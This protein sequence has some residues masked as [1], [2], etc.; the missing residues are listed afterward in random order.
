MGETYAVFGL[1]YCH[2]D[3]GILYSGP[4]GFGLES[5]LLLFS[6]GL[7]G[8]AAGSVSG[9]GPS[10]ALAVHTLPCRPWSLA[11]DARVPIAA[12]GPAWALTV[13]PLECWPWSPGSRTADAA[14]VAGP[15]PD[16]WPPRPSS[17]AP[18]AGGHCRG[19]DSDDEDVSVGTKVR[20]RFPLSPGDVAAPL[21]AA[22]RPLAWQLLPAAA[23]R[24]ACGLLPA[25][26][27][28]LVCGLPPAAPAPLACGLLPV[29]LLP[30]V[31]A[32]LPAAP[33]PLV[34]GLLLAAL[35][36]ES[37]S[38]SQ[39]LF[40][41]K[42][43]TGRIR[44]PR[45]HLL[46]LKI[47]A[48]AAA[49]ALALIVAARLRRDDAVASLRREIHE[50]VAALIADEEDG[51]GGG[52]GGAEEEAS[53]PPPSVLIKGF[54]G[55]GKSS[56]VNTACRALAG[57]DVPLLLRA[58]ASPP[59]GGT[60]GPRRRRRVKAVVSGAE[61]GMSDDMVVELL[62]AP[63][64]PEAGR[65]TREDIDAAIS[66]G[67]PECVVLVLHCDAS[68]KERNAAVKRLAEISA[69]VRA[70]GLNLII[71]L[72][73]K[74]AMRSIRQAEELLREVSFRARTDCVYF[75]ENYTWSNNGPNLRHPPV[76]KNNFEMHFT[77]LTI[78]RQCIVFIKINRCQS[79]D[80]RNGKQVK[81]AESNLK[82]PPAEAKQCRK[83]NDS[84]VRLFFNSSET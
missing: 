81:P 44:V 63:P 51:D 16:D 11:S 60:D 43:P 22:P 82:I 55:H 52:G 8:S 79:K 71:V 26:P 46:L 32:G 73:F 59:G 33:L 48:A 54:R 56:L 53:P 17:F 69:A 75:I 27:A 38:P 34:C 74:K 61:D 23:P 84:S 6:G 31:C 47:A 83:F 57:E 37:Y 2:L 25:A 28:L 66:G 72:T 45:Q 62:D 12:S 5:S 40:I 15:A 42:I 67:D 14:S 4:D 20:G 76:I 21:P 24:P 19:G 65:L 30:L 50:A 3:S 1:R 49:G 70:K 58:E 35:P 80:K 78:I 9:G 36:P 77:V 18:P 64:L 29:V 10:C 39:I 41:T 68:T 13:D 7:F